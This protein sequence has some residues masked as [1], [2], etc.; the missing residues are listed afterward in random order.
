M[1]L[2]GRQSET[3]K[4]SGPV[5]GAAFL[6]MHF[7]RQA[8]SAEACARLCYF[9]FDLAFFF[10]TLFLAVGPLPLRKDGVGQMNAA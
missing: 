8:D 7:V 2:R 1:G 4:R 9:F 3:L 10:I 5:S 6:F